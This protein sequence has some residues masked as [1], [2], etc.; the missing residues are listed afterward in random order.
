MKPGITI[1]AIEVD[2]Y[3]VRY[4]VAFTN[5]ITS[6]GIQF[7]GD[8]E[9][10]SD[11]AKDLISFPKSISDVI[12]FQIGED[13]EDF[14]YYLLLKV[15]CFQANGVSAIEIIMDDHGI[16]P[17]RNKTH[18]FITATPASLNQLGN[19]LA[20]WRTTSGN[21]TLVWVTDN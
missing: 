7:Y 8:D 11:L 20:N 9:T 17:Y 18:F 19:D 4:S 10:F 13:T 1:K 12:S 5:G 2:D 14:A 3:D 6:T 15:Y 16:T 21:K